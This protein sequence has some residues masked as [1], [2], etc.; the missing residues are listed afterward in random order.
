MNYKR[1]IFIL[2]SSLTIITAYSQTTDDD[3][4]VSKCEDNYVFSMKD[5]KPIITNDKYIQYTLASKTYENVTTSVI[6]GNFVSL[7]KAKGDGTALYKNVEEENIFHN[8]TKACIFSLSLDDKHTTKSVH[9]R[10][11]YQDAHYFTCISLNEDYFIKSKTVA[12]VIPK[13]FSAYRIVPRN[14]SSGI[15]CER[16]MNADGDSVITFRLLNVPAIKDEKYMPPYEYISPMALITGSFSDVPDFY[17]W[18]KSKAD[19]DCSVD[20]I[21]DLIVSITQGCTN[22]E[23]RMRKTYRW[24]Q[25]NIR[26][27][28]FEAG[29]SGHVPDTPSQ[30]LRKRY[31]DCKGMALLL[32]TLLKAQHID[33]RLTFLGS[34]DIPYSITEIPSLAT[35]N[36]VIC[37]A[38]VNGR[39]FYL[40]ATARYIPADY[41][42]ADI[43]GR[44]AIMEDGDN[45]SLITLPTLSNAENSDSLMYDYTL[46]ADNSLTGKV[47]YVAT[48]DIKKD[49]LFYYNNLEEQKKQ[50]FLNTRLNDYNQNLT[51]D[52][53]HITADDPMDRT[54][55]FEAKVTNSQAVMA[56]DGKIYV[57]MNPHS[58]ML[59]QRIDTTKRTN[60][61]CM[62][63]K[64]NAVRMFTLHVPGNVS[65]E[66]LPQG[67]HLSTPFGSLSC[68]FRQQ[69]HVITYVQN[70]E[71]S[72][73]RIDRND[74]QRWNEA[75]NKWTDACNE[76]VIL[77][78]K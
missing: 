3:V 31:G 36:H 37:T 14:L 32:R 72:R 15:T 13:Q 12:F 62:N 61:Y 17:R 7:D 59:T 18:L 67:I 49:L 23:Q 27:V 26:Y 38:I 1:L 47:R 71:I 25:Q 20:G 33:A 28:A 29:E 53:A 54:A 77:I 41:T 19:V 11:T 22:D 75:L 44:E 50:D 42:P 16:T 51:I 2:L 74:I 76:Q 4:I 9:F 45:G 6:Y 39:H 60:D 21:S 55:V 64:C 78:K 46:A 63:M 57:E 73:K 70:V 40:D 56:S 52:N 24:V 58:N 65:T 34:D 69:G 68:S 35:I 8:D 48:G 5:G 43:Q 10:R 30:V 66:Y